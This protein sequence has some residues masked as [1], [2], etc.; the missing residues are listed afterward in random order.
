MG[1][2]LLDIV[3][4]SDFEQNV[5]LI[6]SPA[7]ESVQLKTAQKYQRG[8]RKNTVPFA[9]LWAKTKQKYNLNVKIDIK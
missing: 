9:I 8:Q 6:F 3:N 7:S 1:V 2:W 4:D 5:L